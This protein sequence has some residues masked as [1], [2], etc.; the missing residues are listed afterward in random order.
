MKSMDVLSH[1]ITSKSS[2]SCV[3]NEVLSEFVVK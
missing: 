2:T 3:L 1:L